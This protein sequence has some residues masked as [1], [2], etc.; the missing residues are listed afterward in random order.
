MRGNKINGILWILIA[1]FL[2]GVLIRGLSGKDY[3]NMKFWTWHIPEKNILK[4]KIYINGKEYG[5]MKSNSIDSENLQTTD[6]EEG[7][8]TYSFD[9]KKI[10]SLD[11][12]TVSSKIQCFTSNKTD[13]VEIKFSDNID[14]KRLYEVGLKGTTLYLK[15]KSKV[16]F[17]NIH[18][19]TEVIVSVPETMFDS[20]KVESVSG[21]IDAKNLS[22]RNIEISNVSGRIETENLKGKLRLNTVSGRAVYTTD[23]LKNNL[24]I[25][26]VSGTI[27]INI[28]KNADFAADFKTVSGSVTTDFTKTGKKEGTITN[29]DRTYDLRL[30]TVSGSIKIFSF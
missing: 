11:L 9:V 7:Y 25:E 22:A 15:R 17:I 23:E 10:H 16:S 2:M 3:R 21:R 19:A 12:N 1:V 27:E 13:K 24:D 28:P 4:G 29:G 26:S 14:V 30:E 5:R 20:I 6:Y 8:T 18:D